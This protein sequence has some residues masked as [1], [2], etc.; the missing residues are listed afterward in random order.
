[1]KTC[2]LIASFAVGLVG[3]PA[4][5][6]HLPESERAVEGP[7]VPPPLISVPDDVVEAPGWPPPSVTRPATRR[8]RR[9]AHIP[10][11]LLL[12]GGGMLVGGMGGY[13]LGSSVTGC[14]NGS[15]C[16]R[17]TG[18]TLSVGVGM[19]LG[20]ASGV[21]LT[22]QWLGGEGGFGYT[23]LGAALG[24]VPSALMLSSDSDDVAVLG[25]F[26]LL[27]TP[28]VGALFGFGLSHSAT[29]RASMSQAVVVPTVGRTRDGSLVTGLAG[30]F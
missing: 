8:Y 30:R 13:F 10:L 26:A 12:G 16:E 20:V 23:L 14:D 2:C 17:E 24:A 3:M 1:M 6:Q 25:G 4:S 21:Y 15:S 11:G 9:G 22:G 7:S 29:V 27:V 28:F 19:A 5:G 18:L